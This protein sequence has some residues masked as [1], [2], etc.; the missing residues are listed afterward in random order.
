MNNSK[1][2]FSNAKYFIPGGVN[3]PVRSFNN[4][5]GDPFF[6][7]KAQGAYLYDVDDKCYIDYVGSWGSMIMGHNNHRIRKATIA[8]I[9]NGLSFGT[10]TETE[11]LM[12]QLICDLV[13]SIEMIRMVNSGTEATMSA[14]RLARG[15]TRRSKIIKFKGCYH[16]HVDSL[17]LSSDESL[18]NDN[19]LSSSGIPIE[20][21]KNTI[22]C[23]YND[24]DAVHKIFIKYPEDIAAIIVEPVAGNMNCILPKEN[25]LQGLRNLCDEFNSLLI[26]DEVMTGFRVALGGAQQ[27]YNIEPDITCLGK[28]IGGGL[29]VGAFGGKR[30][31]MNK[32]APN[33]PIYQAGTFSGNPVVM[34]AGYSCLKQIIKPHTYKKLNYLTTQLCF[35]LRSAAKINN[36]PIIINNIGGMFGLLFTKD[37]TVNCYSD[38]LRCDFNLFKKFFHLM[39]EKGIYLTPSPFETN[40]VSLSHTMKDI[41]NTVDIANICF[42]KL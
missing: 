22:V 33:G 25:F 16:G 5:G 38:I 15:Y 30:E 26:F 20:C 21:I 6:V 32:L 19:Y 42:S 29:P 18:I 4:V 31:L 40:F 34:A 7:T 1:K 14:I 8:I 37:S 17:L 2:L 41:K 11:N 36:I 13:T 23:E 10:P 27:Y 35:G 28:I 24:L 39:L 9:K 12:A 3:S